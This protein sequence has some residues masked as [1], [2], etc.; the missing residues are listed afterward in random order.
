ME[1]G[2]EPCLEKRLTSLKHRFELL[3]VKTTME[4]KDLG[5]QLESLRE[6]TQSRIF[7]SSAE[8]QRQVEDRVLRQA[9]EHSRRELEQTQQSL[10]QDI[11]GLGL[12]L[13]DT[14]RAIMEQFVN[15]EQRRIFEFI[16]D[17]QRAMR[18]EIADLRL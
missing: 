18:E 16:E 8:L 3:K 6:S 13:E 4:T 12:R 14:R 9:S 2:E 1:H 7:D 5:D 17:S 10:R 15:S 11:A